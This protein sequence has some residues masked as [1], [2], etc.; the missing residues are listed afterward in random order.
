MIGMCN[1]KDMCYRCAQKWA[2]GVSIREEKRRNVGNKRGGE[3]RGRG[4]KRRGGRGKRK[5]VVS[6]VQ[7]RI[8]MS[9]W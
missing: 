8:M 6:Q 9:T 2:A 5:H 4:E 7:E 1:M 3:R